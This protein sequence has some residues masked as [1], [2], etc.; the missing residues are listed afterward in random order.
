MIRILQVVNCMDR[1]GIETM[2]MN[3]YRRI[4]RSKVQ[5]DFLTHRDKKGDYDDEITALGGKIYH[6]P[7]L[8]PQNYIKYKNYMDRFFQEHPEYQVVHSH[9]DAMSAFPLYCA[10]RNHVKVRI[11]HSHNT[12]IDRDFKYPIKMLARHKINH[13]A[14]DFWG[15]G[16]DAVRFLFGEKVF[17]D[18]NY[19]VL[20]NAIDAKVF[21]YNSETRK[22]IREQYGIDEGDVAIGNVARFTRQKNQ[23]FLIDIFAEM[24]KLDSRVTLLLAGT[25]EDLEKIENKVRENNLGD[26]VKF[27]GVIDNV[28]Q[29]LQGLD[30]F[31]LP[32]LYEGLPVVGIEAQAAGLITV[33][34]DTI[35]DETKVTESFKQIDLNA[36]ASVW[37]EK[38]LDL[39][40]NAGK[41][42]SAYEEIKQSGYNIDEEVSKLGNTYIEMWNR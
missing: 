32:S 36:S 26:S 33:A 29:L 1:A 27:L 20:H 17:L 28:P 16:R 31:L 8:Y 9:I 10:K 12:S 7:R 18:H 42:E 38:I 3:Y 35:T 25:G 24:K 11:A 4:D 40:K 13:Y 37:A 30:I 14:T 2:L 19:T 34:S 21:Q 39:Y 6:A 22:M 5:F 15:C 41:R 23:S